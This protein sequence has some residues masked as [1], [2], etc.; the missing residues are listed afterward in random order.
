VRPVTDLLAALRAVPGAAAVLDALAPVPGA[1]VVGGAIRDVL[2]GREPSELDVVVEDDLEAAV[3]A[4]GGEALVHDRFGTAAV[5]ARP[6]RLAVDL[7]RAR[8]ERYPTPGALP[9][10]RPGTLAEDLARR[11]VTINAVAL[12]V[13]GGPPQLRGVEGWEAD[14]EARRLRVLHPSSFIEDPTRLW[15]VAR[16]AARLD[17]E[18]EPL[19]RSL[20]AGAGA[21][22]LSTV[23]GTRLGNE[24]RNAL[25]EPDP[26]GVLRAARELQPA[27]LPG[28]L[29][30]DPAGLDEALV[31]LPPEGDRGL[32]ALAAAAR[33][34]GASELVAWLDALAFPARA[35][36]IVAAGSREVVL[37]PLRAARTPSEIGRAARGAPVE[38][39]ALAGGENA[40][41][42]FDELRD[43]EISISGRDLLDAGVPA[44]PAVGLGLEAALSARLDGGAVTREEQLAAALR[45]AEADGPDT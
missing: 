29:D 38:V 37:A 5:A 32:L 14:M 26:L 2:L 1:W 6:G 27:L 7:V 9:E 36:D 30:L 23:S 35:R 10:V 34:V 39:V 16:Y 11:D 17:L 22:V 24:L 15:R 43:V 20:A 13:G 8:A 42:W 41:R 40:R 18:V 44:G 28:G 45:A 19:T 31:L 4:L 3:A 21:D 25:R 12:C 33:T